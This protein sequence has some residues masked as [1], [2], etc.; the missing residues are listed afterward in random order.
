MRRHDVYTLYL[1]YHSHPI[2]GLLYPGDLILYFFGWANYV[3]GV[4][5]VAP[6]KWYYCMFS[7]AVFLVAIELFKLLALRFIVWTKR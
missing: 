4:G 5:F 3:D 1:S 7:V 6:Y 2:L